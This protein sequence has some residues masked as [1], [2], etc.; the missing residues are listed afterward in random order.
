MTRLD[1]FF[2]APCI[3]VAATLAGTAIWIKIFWSSDE[4]IPFF[5][6]NVVGNFPALPF[7]KR[8]IPQENHNPK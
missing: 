6:A 2:F 1:S 3:Y 5:T 4:T 7:K 8:T